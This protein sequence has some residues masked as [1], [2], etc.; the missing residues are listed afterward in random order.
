MLTGAIFEVGT[1]EVQSAFKYALVNHK[2][3]TTFKMQVSID[4]INTADAFKLSR[5]SKFDPRYTLIIYRLVHFIASKLTSEILGSRE[6]LP[7]KVYMVNK[8]NNSWGIRYGH[9]QIPRDYT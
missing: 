8:V 9:D 3:N 7:E 1:D 6:I 4:L 5:L 2:Q